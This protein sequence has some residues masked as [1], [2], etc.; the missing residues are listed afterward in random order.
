MPSLLLLLGVAASSA[1]APL[2]P[3]VS[4]RGGVSM[5]T[6][7][8][9][10]SGGCHPDPDGTEKKCS[11]YKAAMSWFGNGGRAVHDALSYC[12]QAGLGAAVNDCGLPRRELFVMSMVPT[13]LMGYNLTVASIS[14]SLE[15]MNQTALDLV[16]VHHRAPTAAFPRTVSPMKFFPNT[17]VNSHGKASWGAPPCAVADPTWVRCQDETWDA[18]LAMKKQGLVRAIGVSNWEIPTIQRMIDRSVELPAVNQIEAHIG[19]HPDRLIQFCQQHGIVVQ[20]ATPLGRG[21]KPGFNMNGTV[22]MGA[23]ATVTALATKYKKSPAQISLRF[24]IELGVAVIPSTANPAYQKENLDIFDFK[25]EA[26]E[27]ASLGRIDTQ[28]RSCDNCYKCWGD[29]AA[30]MCTFPNGTMLHC[31]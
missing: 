26:A 8:S 24:L 13:Y 10:S 2:G 20:A 6:V 16:M 15:Q 29:P 9:G 19:W 3:T 21:G 11:N 18:L 12:N 28:C 4:L 30:L 1:A 23:D 22:I 31:P 27:V 14:A 17:P 7:G 25:L 5:P